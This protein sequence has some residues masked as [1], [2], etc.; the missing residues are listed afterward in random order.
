[1][2]GTLCLQAI[3][4]GRAKWASHCGACHHGMPRALTT[5]PACPGSV[6]STR[7]AA[8]AHVVT[9]APALL[10]MSSACERRAL[11]CRMWPMAA[12]VKRV[13]IL[14]VLAGFQRFWKVVMIAA[15]V[16]HRVVAATGKQAAA[17]HDARRADVWGAPQ[18]RH[19]QKQSCL[20]TARS[21]VCIMRMWC[22]CCQE[23][24]IAPTQC[25]ERSCLS[26][27]PCK[28]VWQVISL[29]F[30]LCAPQISCNARCASDKQAWLAPVPMS[31]PTN[32]IAAPPLACQ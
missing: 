1:M 24:Q 21:R 32:V 28:Q 14:P 4:S 8:S 6:S 10:G 26:A 25:K 30:T 23:H 17:W 20:D 18:Q 13:S 27:G 19:Q 31:R 16:H 11:K 22:K 7:A 2:A 9:A 3:R 29:P 5:A 15:A 12:A